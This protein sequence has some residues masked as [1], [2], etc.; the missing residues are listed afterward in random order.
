MATS[1]VL[2][3]TESVRL[4]SRGTHIRAI[5]GA[6]SRRA[7][8]CGSDVSATSS[9]VPA[10]HMQS[11]PTA[12]L[13]PCQCYS[14]KVNLFNIVL[15]LLIIFG[16]LLVKLQIQVLKAPDRPEI[17]VRLPLRCMP[18]PIACWFVRFW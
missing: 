10:D 3:R 8:C 2:T 13:R 6:A 18:I 16:A 5:G 9:R 7:L 11:L 4:W 15:L 14:L 12:Q 1:P 17:F